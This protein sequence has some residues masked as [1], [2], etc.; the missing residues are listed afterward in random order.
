[1]KNVKWK[2]PSHCALNGLAVWCLGMRYVRVKILSR[3]P[4][5]LSNEHDRIFLGHNY[6]LD[7]GGG[8]IVRYGHTFR[9][10]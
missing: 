5:T 6:S 3:A 7:M 4:N 2:S 8:T 10:L 9:C 1:M